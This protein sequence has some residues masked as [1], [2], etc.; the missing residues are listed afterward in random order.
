M[1]RYKGNTIVSAACNC[2][3]KT[4]VVESGIIKEGIASIRIEW[5]YF[6]KK[7]GEIH[8]FDLC[9]SCYEKYI[10]G[11]NHPVRVSPQIEMI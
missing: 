2:C 6:S 7:D 1:R 4:F 5:G 3:G 9:E 10:S 8:D 11:F